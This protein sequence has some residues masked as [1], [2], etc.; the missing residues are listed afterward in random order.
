MLISANIPIE[1]AKNSTKEETKRDQ[2]GN[3]GEQQNT[4]WYFFGRL[5]FVVAQSCLLIPSLFPLFYHRR[6]VFVLKWKESGAS[7]QIKYQCNPVVK[8]YGDSL[9]TSEI[10]S[11]KYKV[12]LPRYDQR[13]WE[14]TSRPSE[15]A[16][17]NNFL[18]MNSLEIYR[19]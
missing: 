7:D 12:K 16:L 4:I 8:K 3:K 9:D 18:N 11:K 10:L 6:F 19:R 5:F 13:E 1:E 14:A 15:L 17:I 2:G